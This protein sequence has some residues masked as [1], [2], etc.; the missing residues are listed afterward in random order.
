MPERMPPDDDP[1]IR[2][3]RDA[4]IRPLHPPGSEPNVRIPR[5]VVL[6]IAAVLALLLFLPFAAGRLADW[7]WY[8]EIGFERVFFTK[9]IAQWVLGVPTALVAFA[10]LYGNARFALRDGE[11]RQRRS[12]IAQVQSSADLRDVAQAMLARGIDWLATPVSLLLGL[13]VTL[14]A[15]GQWRL[16]L[17]AAYATPFGV[18]DP[19]F[20]RDAGYYV[21][22]LPAIDLVTGLVFGLLMIALI[23]IVLPIH[24]FR[25]EVARTVQ[26]LLVGRRAQKQ[27]GLI[28][29][30]MLLLTAVRIRF[31]RIPGLLFGEH[32]PLS[33]ANY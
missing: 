28:I 4:G 29:G 5:S 18:T 15:A 14:A 3:L 19:V 25:G 9:I 26:G 23:A 22:S 11:P 32:L 24:L 10:V 6:S 20:G 1:I 12:P 2:S 16:V 31:V 7:L 17:Q 21:F 30:L 13:L 8:R 27:L 33:G